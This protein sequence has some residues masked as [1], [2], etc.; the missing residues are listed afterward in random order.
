MARP[1]ESAASGKN[2]WMFVPVL[3]INGKPTDTTSWNARRAANAVGRD[4][5][6][7]PGAQWGCTV[8]LIKRGS[9]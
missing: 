1:A 4:R 5:M 2:D 3:T 8:S 9:W 6:T 7:T